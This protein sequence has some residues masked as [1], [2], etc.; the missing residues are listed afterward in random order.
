MEALERAKLPV[1]AAV[2]RPIRSATGVHCSACG[3][4]HPARWHTGGRQAVVRSARSSPGPAER[5][6]RASDGMQR[7][8]LTAPWIQV[9]WTE[10][11]LAQPDG[12]GLLMPHPPTDPTSASRLSPLDCLAANASSPAA[13]VAASVEQAELPELTDPATG[14]RSR[15]GS[16]SGPSAPTEPGRTHSPRRSTAAGRTELGVRRPLA[17]R[18]PADRREQAISAIAD[19][20][21]GQLEREAQQPAL[22]ARGRGRVAGSSRRQEELP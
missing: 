17:G 21:I 22:A 2:D 3:A 4:S 15:W 20:L 7:R 6:C 14:R 1:R 10:G 13:A 8:P 16:R 19:L 9:V 12:R 5:T 11:S 18:M